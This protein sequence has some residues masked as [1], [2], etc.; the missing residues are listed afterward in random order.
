MAHSSEMRWELAQSLVSAAAEAVL[1][2]LNEAEQIYLDLLEI[3][4]YTGNSHQ[5]MA[6]LL[7][8][9]VIAAEQR[10]PAEANAFEVAKVTDLKNCIQALHQLHQALNN[11]V[12]T[13]ADRATVL[14]RMG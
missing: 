4:P 3:Y 11:E 5:L 8:A 14:R 10:A 13:Q 9:D 12:T 1:S 2:N 7:F 6:D